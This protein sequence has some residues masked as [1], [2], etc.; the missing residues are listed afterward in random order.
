MPHSQRGWAGQCCPREEAGKSWTGSCSDEAKRKVAVLAAPQ[1]PLRPNSARFQH[2]GELPPAAQAALVRTPLGRHQEVHGEALVW[3][4]P[5]GVCVC[6]LGGSR[7]GGVALPLPLSERFSN[8]TGDSE[9]LSA[10]GQGTFRTRFSFRSPQQ[11]AHRRP[12]P[13]L[14]STSPHPTQHVGRRDWNQLL[15]VSLLWIHG[16]NSLS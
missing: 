2:S 11:A 8:L 12:Q 16:F 6:V 3:S 7:G 13:L 5:E 15:M 4:G 9:G 1:T 10:G 14:A